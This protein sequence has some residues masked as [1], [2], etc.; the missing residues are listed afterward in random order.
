MLNR[1]EY[2]IVST[3]IV[4]GEELKIHNQ[5]YATNNSAPSHQVGFSP[6][7]KRSPEVVRQLEPNVPSIEVIE[8][9]PPSPKRPSLLRVPSFNNGSHWDQEVSHKRLS[10]I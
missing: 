4:Q 1:F 8:E 7:L 2:L 6:T 9:T 3:Y 5:T 10:Q